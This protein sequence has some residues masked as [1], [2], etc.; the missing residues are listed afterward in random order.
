M[1]LLAWPG[2]QGE[3]LHHV[4]T[5]PLRRDM[6]LFCSGFRWLASLPAPDSCGHP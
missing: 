3:L 1:R 5:C 4:F 6:D 2:L